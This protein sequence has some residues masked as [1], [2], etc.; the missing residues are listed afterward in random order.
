MKFTQFNLVLSPFLLILVAACSA[1]G[2]KIQA[3]KEFVKTEAPVY[4]DARLLDTLTPGKSCDEVNSSLG[5]PVYTLSDGAGTTAKYE[6]SVKASLV[7]FSKTES[8]AGNE[9]RTS[10]IQEPIFIRTLFVIFDGKCRL[11]DYQY[12]SSYPLN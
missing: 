5:E 7:E 6:Y 4:F 2:G 9:I 10:P 1:S 12:I 11:S 3:E 8:K